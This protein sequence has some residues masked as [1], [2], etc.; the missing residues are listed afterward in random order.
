MACTHALTTVCPALLQLVGGPGTAKTSTI[1]Q[2]VGRFNKEE[3]S[4]KTITFSYLTTPGIFQ[5]SPHLQ[6]MACRQWGRLWTY[7]GLHNK[8]HQPLF[9]VPPFL[10][11]PP[12][13]LQSRAQW[14]SARAVPLDPPAASP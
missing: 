14:R 4:N 10:F 12:L 6:A 7:Q 5:V 11:P 8:G 13:R 3:H 9:D 1:Q 2:F